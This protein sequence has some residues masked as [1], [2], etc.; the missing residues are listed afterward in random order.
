[1]TKIVNVS[2]IVC[3]VKKFGVG[4]DKIPKELLLREVIKHKERSEGICDVSNYK[5]HIEICKQLRIID[6][7]DEN[8]FLTKNGIE[9]YELIP[10]ESVIK[11]I[12]RKNDELK[13][14]V[15]SLIL[16]D[17]NWL[18]EVTKESSKNILIVDGE[19][20][21]VS[22]NEE[23]MKI[24]KR[25]RNLLKDVGLVEFQ[26]QGQ[27]I[28]PKLSQHIPKTNQGAMSEKEFF[29]VLEKQR[30]NGE[31]AEEMTVEWE[32]KRLEVLGVRKAIVDTVKRISTENVRAGYD[33]KSYEGP[34][35]STEYD[36]FIEVKA[37]TSSSPVF[38]W[39]ENER[40]VAKKVGEKYFIY[41]WTNWGKPEQE[42][43][44]VII[45]NPYYEI[46]E[47][48]YEQVHVI[49]TWRVLWHE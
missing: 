44:P 2:K 6:E 33:I 10:E 13:K 40:S 5:K 21:I 34:I 8:I 22:T 14:K 3:I 29:D 7:I 42:K 37:T 4:S 23:W 1:M 47:K 39:S 16:A 26:N 15:Q 46:V 35:V 11:I 31:E 32:R 27:E 28:S 20:K 49:E 45:K 25:I 19:T 18:K 12:D 36:R 24:N 41:I 9:I 48:Q 30:K 17:K 43:D 38:Y